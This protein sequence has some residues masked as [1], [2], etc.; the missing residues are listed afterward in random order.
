ML[1]NKLFRG[2]LREPNN[3]VPAGGVQLTGDEA[4]DREAILK[5]DVERLVKENLKASKTQETIVGEEKQEPTNFKIQLFGQEFEYP[6]YQTAMKAVEATISD[7]QRAAA[8]KEAVK[9][10]KKEDEFSKDIFA[11]KVTK[12]PLEGIRYALNN[13]SEFKNLARD[14]ENLKQALAVAQFRS[15]TNGFS[16][17]PQTVQAM[18][19]HMQELGLNPNNP[20]SL[21]AAYALGVQRGTIKPKTQQVA[22][23][24]QSEKFVPGSGR[25]YSNESGAGVPESFAI[26]ARQLTKQQRAEL[27]EKYKSGIQ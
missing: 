2:V 6:D 9:E 10:T 23:T 3:G 16:P 1:F 25:G 27:I 21:E 17:D 12:D 22:E 26:A 8:N 4:A 13:L 7:L 14:N 15:N 18:N 19:A 24:K 11:E 20:A 5:A